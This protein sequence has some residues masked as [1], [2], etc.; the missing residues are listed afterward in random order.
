VCIAWDM[1][2]EATLQLVS[3]TRDC[4]VQL[5]SFNGRDL[6]CNFSVRLAFTI[7]AT[8]AFANNTEGDIYVFGIYS[9]NW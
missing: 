8:V 3:G 2:N 9:G 4:H 1:H 6:H 7:L 5:W